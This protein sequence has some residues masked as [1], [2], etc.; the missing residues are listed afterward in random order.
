MIYI[1]FVYAQEVNRV[2]I[3]IATKPL[4][5]MWGLNT[6]SPCS[7]V[8]LGVVIGTRAKEKSLHKRFA[9]LRTHNEWFTYADEIRAYVKA[10]ARPYDSTRLVEKSA[11]D[12]L[13][14]FLDSMGID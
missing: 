11:E 13:D 5:R 10:N 3:G 7:L 14:D 8:L 12:D 4:E 2:K 6:D 1:Y 9:H